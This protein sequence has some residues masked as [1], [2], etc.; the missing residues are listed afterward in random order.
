MVRGIPKFKIIRGDVCIAYVV[1]IHHQNPFLLKKE[2]NRVRSPIILCTLMFV[3][4]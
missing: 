1:E 2:N 4:Q 3:N